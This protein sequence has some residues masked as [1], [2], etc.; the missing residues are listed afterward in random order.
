M[1]NILKTIT[2]IHPEKIVNDDNY[3][4]YLAL[5]SD[6]LVV[7]DKQLNFVEWIVI[8]NDNAGIYISANDE[9][10]FLDYIILLKKLILSG[11]NP[12]ELIKNSRI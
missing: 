7:I 4:Y 10:E 8:G 11:I 9:N 2:L 1:N 12:V 6:T 5:S 3:E